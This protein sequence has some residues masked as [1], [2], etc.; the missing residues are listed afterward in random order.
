MT[1]ARRSLCG[2]P[3]PVAGPGYRDGDRGADAATVRAVPPGNSVPP[4]DPLTFR[5][6]RR[7]RAVMELDDIQKSHCN[8]RACLRHEPGP[9]TSR[10]K[11]PESGSGRRVVRCVGF[12]LHWVGAPRAAR[13]RST[14]LNA[15]RASRS[16]LRRSA[17]RSGD[18]EYSGKI[19][20]RLEGPRPL[21]VRATHALP[22]DSAN[23]RPVRSA[24]LRRAASIISSRRERAA[25]PSRASHWRIYRLF[26]A[27]EGLSSQGSALTEF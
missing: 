20:L 16:R 12:A 27:N 23:H 6:A 13:G 2:R 18:F 21:P 7:Q 3:S 19:L 1:R 10:S 24:G 25:T 11:M 8:A 14:T 17:A 5:H 26:D 15:R 4:P 9:T 22:R